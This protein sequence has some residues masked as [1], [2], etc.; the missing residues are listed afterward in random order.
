MSTHPTL[1]DYIGIAPTSNLELAKLIEKGLSTHSLDLLKQRGLTAAEI[2]ATIISPRTL[3]RREAHTGLL[4]WLESERAVRMASIV[5][6][7]ELSFGNLE[8][9]LGW[10]R[11]TND[12]LRCRTP[13]S[14]LRTDPGGCLIES[15]LSDI[16]A[17]DMCCERS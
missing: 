10:L 4:T 14:M 3:R 7:A 6:L 8:I 15:M 17:G 12:R 1:K 9:A 2:A 11:Q 5:C 16:A 13:L